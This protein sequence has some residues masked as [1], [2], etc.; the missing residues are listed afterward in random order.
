MGQEAD[1]R[2]D[3]W[4]FGCCLY[5]ALTGCAPFSGGTDSDRTSEILEKDPNWDL[6]PSSL[7]DA[8]GDLI[9]SCLEKEPGSRFSSAGEMITLLEEA[10][11]SLKRNPE[12]V[13]PRQKLSVVASLPIAASVL[14]VVVGFG[15]AYLLDRENQ[16]SREHA[17]AIDV[18]S[19]RSLAI[20]PLK[21]LSKGRDQEAFVDRMTDVLATELSRVSSLTIKSLDSTRAYHGTGKTIRNISQELGVDAVITGS[22]I[23]NEDEVQIELALV[24]GR[25]ESELW[26]HSY[27]SPVESSL[28]LQ[29]EIALAI[30]NETKAAI[31][32]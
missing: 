12:P 32:P 14:I 27:A 20:L 25:T 23:R 30:A 1:E 29:S 13:V 15:S 21:D 31:A 18:V 17:R 7:P 4:A 11:E 6:L 28:G 19:I 3:I 10:Q 8:V 16:P 24:D 2:T 26:T 5:E 22:A 9:R